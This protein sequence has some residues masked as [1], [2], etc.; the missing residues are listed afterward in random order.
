M[1]SF[2]EFLNEKNNKFQKAKSFA[3]SAWL[4]NAKKT[5]K[6]ATNSDAPEKIRNPENISAL[7][8]AISSW[9]DNPKMKGAYQT[10]KTLTKS[11]DT[12]GEEEKESPKSDKDEKGLNKEKTP[13][14]NLQNDTENAMASQ[15]Q[16]EHEQEVKDNVE[17]LQDKDPDSVEK[18]REA[19][20]EEDLAKK[21]AEDN[22]YN[23]EI[24][25]QEER[26]KFLKTLADLISLIF[27]GAKTDSITDD[28]DKKIEKLK[29]KQSTIEKVNELKKTKTNEKEKISDKY[30]T[31]ADSAQKV[32]K[33]K[34]KV[35][36]NSPCP[37]VVAKAKEHIENRKKALDSK[38]KELKE[39]YSDEKNN[40]PDYEEKKKMYAEYEQLCK[41]KGSDLTSDDI[42]RLNEL[43]DI[44]GI[45]KAM[46][47]WDKNNV[48]DEKAAEQETKEWRKREL[49]KL[50]RNQENRMK[51]IES[52]KNLDLAKAEKEENELN[53][54]IDD[55]MKKIDK[56]TLN[57]ED[58]KKLG[59]Y[60]SSMANDKNED[61]SDLN[62][63]LEQEEN[64]TKQK[65]KEQTELEDIKKKLPTNAPA[66]IKH[67]S[68][69][70]DIEE[71]L[72][73]N[74]KNESY[75][76]FL[77]NKKLYE[78]KIDNEYKKMLKQFL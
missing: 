59:N 34:E 20:A 60:L 50:K 71:W 56:G 12:S 10:V 14:E 66:Y 72:K 22:I 3:L 16:E 11:H 30:K 42:K 57:S 49:E 7:M 61:K 37:D 25:R 15:E 46:K 19:S 68:N 8:R 38:R 77:N 48:Y 43:N 51:E 17:F 5:N 41:K 65:E 31:I 28:A 32:A 45:S 2:K 75:K 78:N 62:K 6:N 55:Y 26:K 33:A 39:L 24:E 21:F 27:K 18:Y 40:S 70:D 35:I 29:E 23:A 53:D 4:K 1:I 74:A 63:S 69:K 58:R 9:K 76:V 13:E 47:E 36:E 44:F 54:Y 64:E 73:N 52:A 67:S